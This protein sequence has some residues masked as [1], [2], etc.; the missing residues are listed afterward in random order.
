MTDLSTKIATLTEGIQQ[1][2]RRKLVSKCMKVADVLG[3][4][5]ESGYIKGNSGLESN[6]EYIGDSLKINY[7]DITIFLDEDSSESFVTIEYKKNGVF[8]SDSTYSECFNVTSEIGFPNNEINLEGEFVYVPGYWERKLNS[9][10]KAAL[11]IE[12]ERAADLKCAAERLRG[13]LGRLPVR[14]LDY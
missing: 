11:A 5:I 9:K 1:A 4:L 10:Y 7:R 12:E 3:D 6:F 14:G 13:D 2:R 8:T